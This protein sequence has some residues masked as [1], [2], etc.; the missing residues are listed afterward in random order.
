MKLWGGPVR[1][2]LPLLAGVFSLLPLLWFTHV[3]LSERGDPLGARFDLGLWVSASVLKLAAFAVHFW[4]LGHVHKALFASR[5]RATAA[6][7]IWT[8][9]LG[10]LVVLFAVTR[11]VWAPLLETDAAKFFYAGESH[12][13]FVSEHRNAW[14]RAWPLGVVA[15]EIV[16]LSAASAVHAALGYLLGKYPALSALLACV[17]TDALVAGY[18][19]VCPW[20]TWDFDFFHGDLIASAI[21]LDHF[22]M[23]MDPYT[24]FTVPLYLALVLSHL[25]I[26]RIMRTNTANLGAQAALTG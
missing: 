5:Q 26:L 16:L 11:Q 18:V 3:Y 17:A 13:R 9:T 19:F 22:P 20:V 8:L 24:S 10:T 14:L 12:G 1:R 7:A 15:G 4:L 2:G 6:F 21:L 25:A 23:G